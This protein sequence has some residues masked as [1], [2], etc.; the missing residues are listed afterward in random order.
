MNEENH[1]H[2]RVSKDT[3]RLLQVQEARQDAKLQFMH[4]LWVSN[5][6]SERRATWI[7]ISQ[8]RW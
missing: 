4:V 2:Q 5:P 3:Y 8:K 1:P 6:Q 7:V